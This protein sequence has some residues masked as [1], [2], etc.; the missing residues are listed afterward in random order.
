MRETI[1]HRHD[2]ARKWRERT[3]GR[4]IGYLCTYVPEEMVYA[5]GFL[6]V[7]VMGS[8]EPQDITDT[9]IFSMYCPFC[10]DCLAQGLLGRYDYLDGL[11]AAHSCMHIRQTFDS[12]RRHI[13]IPYT[14]YLFMPA[15]T[16][17]SG[18][19]DCFRGE[20][21][22]F[23]RSLESWSGVPLSE[24]RL[25]EAIEV[26]NTNRRL[27]RRLYSL[28]KRDHP[29]IS[30]A[31]AM[32]AV[33]AGMLMDKAEHN[34]LLEE[35]LSELEGSAG[36]GYE[37]VRLM[38]LGSENDDI[39]FT[40]FTESLGGMVVI[41][42]QCT[43]TR[44]FWGEVSTDGDL[45]EAIARRYVERP[46]CPQKDLVGR[47]RLEH[48][49]NLAEEW[50]PQG[51]ILALQKF[52]DPHEFDMPVIQ[53]ALQKRGIPCLLLEFDITIPVGQFRTRIEAFLEMLQLEII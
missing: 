42:E 2:Y 22:R 46:P 24:E 25:R 27:L 3:G 14:H 5:A 52:C 31:E 13:P 8:H 37:G 20:L 41:D 32:E 17:T 34:R 49:L 43:G 10:R 26:Y 53:E 39:E 48:V 30:G 35:L 29:P 23:R 19:L 18:A 47:R 51:A 15:N 16:G 4:V 36:D 38:M 44:Y 21:H 12:W 9:H 7:R 45:L 6:P 40:R 28:R 1:A 50:R 11:V 33:L